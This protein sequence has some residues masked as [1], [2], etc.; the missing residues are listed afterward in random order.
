MRSV[1]TEAASA[2]CSRAG[3]A[4]SIGGAIRR[5]VRMH[6][7]DKEEITEAGAGDICAIF[8]V[9]CNSGDT[10]TDGTVNLAMTS[11]FVPKPYDPFSIGRLLDYLVAAKRISAPLGAVGKA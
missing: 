7:D 9:D 4:L 11:M 1:G 6:S 2:S 3:G 10:F 5:L 8:G